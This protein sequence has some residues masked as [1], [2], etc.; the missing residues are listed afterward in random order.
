MISL[1]D[2]EVVKYGKRNKEKAVYTAPRLGLPHF[3]VIEARE[4]LLDILQNERHKETE[5]LGVSLKDF[6]S[7]RVH[8]VLSG[9]GED[10]TEEQAT[11][12][13]RRK[14]YVPN[15]Q[16]DLW[17]RR[18]TVYETNDLVIEEDAEGNVS[19][20][21][22]KPKTY[23]DSSRGY[24][25][26]GRGRGRGSSGRGSFGR[27]VPAQPS[28]MPDA[29]IEVPKPRGTERSKRQQKALN[30]LEISML[31]R[32]IRPKVKT[33]NSSFSEKLGGWHLL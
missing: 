28:D 16:Q 33:H 19:Y 8:W 27:G 11:F 23:A 9:L 21:E 29:M 25:G 1:E 7:N 32:T 14:W 12:N 10:I 15:N 22:A 20:H 4:P 18:I 24:R 31:M 3:V 13:K 30:E 6:K 2:W 26:Q 17:T 5:R